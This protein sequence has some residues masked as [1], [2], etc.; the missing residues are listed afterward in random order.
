MA[1]PYV[2]YEG[3]VVTREEAKAIGLTRFF[4]GKPCKHGH[5]FQRTTCNGGCIQCNAESISAL[6]YAEPPDKRTVRQARGKIWKDGNRE[7][8]RNAGLSGSQYSKAHQ[9]QSK[10]WKAA[11]R[12]KVLEGSRDYYQRL[13]E[14]I[15]AKCAARYAADPNP[16]RVLSHRRRARLLNAEGSHTKEDIRRIGALQKWKCHWCGVPTKQKFHLDHLVPISKGGT[17]WPNNLVIACARCNLQ[18]QDADPI[19]F[20]R[21]LG[22]LV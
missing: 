16:S 1:K 17:N 13:R 21:R 5:L 14:D 6:Y 8:V 11:N 2:P 18:K 19:D 12:D 22:R 3:P 15:L 7:Q 10:A 9:K 4:T 20:A